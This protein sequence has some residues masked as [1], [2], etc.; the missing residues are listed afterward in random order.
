MD[1]ISENS[2]L[3]IFPYFKRGDREIV[4]EILSCA[5]YETFPGNT[6]MQLAGEPC[7]SLGLMLS[8]VKRIYKSSGNGREIT[9]YEV[10]PGET[11]ILNASCILSN[12]ICPVNAVSVGDVSFLGISARDFRKL[13]AR[14]EEMRIFVFT[15]ISS[16]FAAIIE[17]LQEVAFGRMDERLMDYLVEKSEEGR[18]KTTHQQ[19]ADDLGTARE[20]VS[21]LLKEFER[22]GEVRLSRNQI[23]LARL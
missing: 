3:Q 9:L 13:I 8:G 7:D 10:G 11:C 17:L 5:R 20:V 2:F 15:A 12:V 4:C 23:E 1:R 21:R 19:I 18:L 22:R 14:Y 6:I 16:N